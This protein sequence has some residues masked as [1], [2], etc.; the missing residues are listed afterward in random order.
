MS[1]AHFIIKTKQC[2]HAD[3][4]YFQ[5]ENKHFDIRTNQAYVFWFATAQHRAGWAARDSTLCL[6]LLFSYIQ[7][8]FRMSNLESVLKGSV[9]LQRPRRKLVM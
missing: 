8:M 4:F 7:I 5:T 9:F 2:V 1:N 3:L 6:S